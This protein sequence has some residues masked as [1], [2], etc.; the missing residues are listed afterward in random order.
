MKRLKNLTL[1]L[2][3]IILTA[4]ATATPY[5]PS[6]NADLRNGFSE[7][8]I[9][10]DR[11]MVTFD[12]NTMTDRQTVET[13][14]L[15]RAAELTKQAGYDYFILTDRAVDKQTEVRNMGYTSPYYGMFDYSYYSPRRGWSRPYYRPYYPWYG[16]PGRYDPFYDRWGYSDFDYREITRY[17]ATAE[18]KFAR[19]RKPESMANAFDAGE[20]LTNLRGKIVYPEQTG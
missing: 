20:V 9:E 8:K 2:G 10:N 14:L 16:R 18:V 7:T 12:G 19:G 5:Q 13:Y 4:C 11:I 15:Y 3:A 17:R 1:A 6:N